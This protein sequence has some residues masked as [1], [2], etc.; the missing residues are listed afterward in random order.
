[1]NGIL[2]FA[3][4]AASILTLQLTP[5][6]WAAATLVAVALIELLLSVLIGRDVIDTGSTTYLARHYFVLDPTSLLFVLL[7]NGVFVGIAVHM[8]SRVLSE[9]ALEEQMPFVAGLSLAFMASMNAALLSNHLVVTWACIEVTTLAAAPLVALGELGAQRAAFRYFLYSTVS[10]ALSFF[11]LLCLA[12]SAHLRG[13][14]LSFFFDE[15][16]RS[17]AAHGDVWQQVGLSLLLF[18][19]GSK[20]GLAPLYGWLPETYD[21]A[22]PSVTAMLASIQFNASVLAIFR[23][24]QVCRG[25]DLGFVSR[26]LLIMGALSLFVATIQIMAARH[27]KRL[28]AYACVS[29]SGV[30]AIG[31]AVG[32]SAAYGVILYVVSNAF[33]KTLLFLTA[34][35]LKSAYGSKEVSALSGVIKRMPFAGLL[36]TVGTFALLGFPPFGSFMAEMLILS[37]I[38]QGG[39]LWVFTILCTMLTIIFVATGRAL[40][41]MLWGPTTNAPRPH[42][43]ALAATP[44]VAFV[45]ALVSLGIYVPEPVARLLRT[46]AASIGGS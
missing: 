15:L 21:S 45:L 13:G 6:R 11:G 17:I 37:G 27:Y 12:Q 33:V 40:F 20:L 16:P 1:V 24:L 41:P 3:V 4:P 19:F 34:G 28:I 23:I 5:R 32:R 30:I 36:F 31:L 7:V 35:R 10:L 22:P 42:E 43:S 38:A 18:G 2:T 14:E 9:P 29:S 26:E 8:L 46:V 25:A 44:K 39:H